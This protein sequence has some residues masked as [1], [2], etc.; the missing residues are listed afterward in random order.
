[1]TASDG[2]RPAVAGPVPVR[3]CG[4]DDLRGTGPRGHV[5]GTVRLLN[6]MRHLMCE[7]PQ[8]RIA[9]WPVQVRTKK[10][11]RSSG[12]RIGLHRAR[13]VVGSRTGVDP[14]SRQVHIEAAFERMSRTGIQG[15]ALRYSGTDLGQHVS[16]V[17]QRS[18]CTPHGSVVLLVPGLW[19]TAL[20]RLTRAH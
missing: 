12:E 3:P 19:S 11:M 8:S 15:A 5:V 20:P 18:G 14:D 17:N 16:C 9:F 4:R 13:E 6:G 2:H 7:K 1:M 10:E